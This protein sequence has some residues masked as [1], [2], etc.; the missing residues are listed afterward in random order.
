MAVPDDN[1][2]TGA[3]RGINDGGAI[4]DRKRHWLFDE[5]MFAGPGGKDR[6][7]TVELVRRGHVDGVDGRV[8]AQI[9]DR[10]VGHRR[11]L[12]GEPLAGLVARI[13][14]SHQRHRRV[15]RKCLQ[16]R[17]KG[18]AQSGDA[19]TQWSDSRVSHRQGPALSIVL[20]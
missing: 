14:R 5:Q 19:H 12:L 3:P 7:L 6:V 1:V 18:A 15:A 16:H 17:R 20:S 10:L 8:D 2:H 4:L 9:R 11:E 13:R